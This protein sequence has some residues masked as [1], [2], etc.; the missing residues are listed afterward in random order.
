M[1]NQIGILFVILSPKPM[2]NQIGILLL[3]P[4]NIVSNC[5]ILIIVDGVCMIYHLYIIY[6]SIPSAKLWLPPA[7]SGCQG[8][9]LAAVEKDLH[10][11]PKIGSKSSG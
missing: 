5:L 3:N 10:Q 4:V 2:L 9:D 11:Q 1:L 6:F 8:P 7:P